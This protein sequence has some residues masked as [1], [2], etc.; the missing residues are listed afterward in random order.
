MARASTQISAFHAK[1][2]LGRLLD[3]VVAGEELVITRRGEPVARLVPVDNSAK[4]KL[5]SAIETFREVRA[6]LKARKV[7]VSRAE[8]R[9]WR[10]EGRK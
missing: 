5:A 2:G 1:N 10:D 6:S 8:V 4:D 7:K 9:E 3:R